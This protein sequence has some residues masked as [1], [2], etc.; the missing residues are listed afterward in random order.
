MQSRQEAKRTCIRILR[1]LV[2]RARYP[3]RKQ[4]VHV[5]A[6]RR[7]PVSATDVCHRY[8]PPVSATGIRLQDAKRACIR[9]ASANGIRHRR[10]PPVSATGIRLQDAK[11]DVSAYYVSHFFAP[12]I[13]PGC[14]THTDAQTASPRGRSHFLSLVVLCLFHLTN[15]MDTCWSLPTDRQQS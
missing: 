5:S 6:R 14:E 13:R 2:F 7:R 8:P 4:N 3:P 1:F 9:S 11:R 15:T 12:G 10:P